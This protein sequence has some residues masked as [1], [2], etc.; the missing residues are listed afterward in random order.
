MKKVVKYSIKMSGKK[1]EGFGMSAEEFLPI[2]VP[3]LNHLWT[4]LKTQLSPAE[5]EAWLDAYPGI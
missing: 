4:N 2:A 3:S 1:G 5:K